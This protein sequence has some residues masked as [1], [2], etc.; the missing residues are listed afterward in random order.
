M[1]ALVKDR[2]V[3]SAEVATYLGVTTRTLR[4]WAASGYGPQRRKVGRLVKYRWS[5][6][7]AFVGEESP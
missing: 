3:D 1:T 4:N 5:E 2:L 7:T 6:V